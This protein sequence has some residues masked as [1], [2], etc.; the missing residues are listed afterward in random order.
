M[1]TDRNVCAPQPSEITF[2]NILRT[3]F[4]PRTIIG[5]TDSGNCR[6][7]HKYSDFG[8]LNNKN[9]PLASL[10]D[11]SCQ[12][13]LSKVWRIEDYSQNRAVLQVSLSSLAM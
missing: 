5:S 4:C 6:A 8:F 2:V 10:F 1:K 12:V 3:Y 9:V 11:N 13:G 7:G